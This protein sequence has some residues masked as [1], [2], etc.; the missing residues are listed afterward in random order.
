MSTHQLKPHQASSTS[1][2]LVVQLPSK[3]I[4][5]C[6]CERTNYVY[7][8]PISVVFCSVCPGPCAAFQDLQEQLIPP[9][10]PDTEWRSLMQLSTDLQET[11]AAVSLELGSYGYGSTTESGYGYGS[12]T[13][14][15]SSR[16]MLLQ[17]VDAA[18]AALLLQPGS[19]SA[20]T[21]G[22]YSAA[23]VAEAA[24]AAG[25]YGEA[26]ANTD[27][28][29]G[30]GGTRRLL[31]QGGLTSGSYGSAAAVPAGSYGDA[32]ASTAEGMYG[33]MR[34]LLQEQAS[35]QDS[36]PV[37]TYGSSNSNSHVV[38]VIDVPGEL[39]LFL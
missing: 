30:Y 2:N 20:E 28:A 34:R 35:S 22:S 18:S 17:Q 27:E 11:A 9:V 21:D 32:A 33:S 39:P 36:T 29:L 3:L 14:Q 5:A 24:A 12:G 26:T 16:R 4:S 25:S 38:L 23:A 13:S 8:N 6:P 37:L 7:H 15:D 31:Q 1:Q 10:V 19:Y